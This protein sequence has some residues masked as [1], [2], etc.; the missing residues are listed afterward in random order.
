[1]AATAQQLLDAANDALLRIL[2]DQTASYTIGPIT[3]NRLNLDELRKFRDAL[4]AEVA[5]STSGRQTI[6][7][8]SVRGR[9][10]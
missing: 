5:G 1:M 8:A 9:P 4:E 7:H 3:Y 10:R 6:I 2:Q